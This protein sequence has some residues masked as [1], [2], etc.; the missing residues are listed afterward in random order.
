LGKGVGKIQGATSDWQCPWAFA[1]LSMPMA[2]TMAYF[3]LA[4]PHLWAEEMSRNSG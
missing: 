4:K 1:A 2:T 3:K